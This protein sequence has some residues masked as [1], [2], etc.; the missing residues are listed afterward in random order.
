MIARF[1]IATFMIL[2]LIVWAMVNL[3]I[4]VDTARRVVLGTVGTDY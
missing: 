4:P 1:S 3:S 2:K